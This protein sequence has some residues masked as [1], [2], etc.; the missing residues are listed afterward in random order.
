VHGQRPSPQALEGLLVRRGRFRPQTLQR[1]LERRALV[2]RAHGLGQ[3]QSEPFLGNFNDELILRDEG[4]TTR[5]LI[6][7]DTK[8]SKKMC[9]P[10]DLHVMPFLG[11]MMSIMQGA[12]AVIDQAG[13]TIIV[14]FYED[15]SEDVSKLWS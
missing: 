11:L 14:E 8:F 15:V 2:R 12:F 9:P 7:D 6:H 1:L 10:G 3:H 5:L 13:G 4:K